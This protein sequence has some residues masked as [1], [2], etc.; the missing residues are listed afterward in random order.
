[1]KIISQSLLTIMLVALLMS[2]P[3]AAGEVVQANSGREGQAINPKSLMVPGRPVVIYLFSP[4]CP[5][6]L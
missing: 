2:Q 1:V 3:V 5:P 6:C 4:Y